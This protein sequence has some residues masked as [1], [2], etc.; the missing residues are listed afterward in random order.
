VTVDVG[1][2]GHITGSVPCPELTTCGPVRFPFG[3]SVT[4]HAVLDGTNQVGW[5]GACNNS[6][7]TTCSFNVGTQPGSVTLV[8]VTFLIVDKCP[9]VCGPPAVNSQ[10]T[11]RTGSRGPLEPARLPDPPDPLPTGRRRR[12][13]RP[14]RG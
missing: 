12:R 14:D 13:A 5:D 9:P 8:Q 3:Q 10:S 4:L 7:S 11:G 1:A 2:G 6:S